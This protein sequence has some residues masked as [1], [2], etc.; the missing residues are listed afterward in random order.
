MTATTE[1]TDTPQPN[2]QGGES[3]EATSTTPA[4]SE[5]TEKSEPQG[6]QIASLLDDPKPDEKAGEGGG[7]S[8]EAK[9][10]TD[11][12]G[13]SEGEPE[14]APEAYEPFE[15][16][17]G[18]QLDETLMTSFEEAARALNLP[19]AKAQG[20]LNTMLPAMVQLEQKRLAQ[21]DADTIADPEIGGD[22]HDATIDA[23]RKALA[24]YGNKAF[25]QM[26]DQTG[27]HRHP[28]MKRMLAWVG[29]RISEDTHVGEGVPDSGNTGEMTDA[30]MRNVLHG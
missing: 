26:L 1:T 8:T 17:E 10:D 21:W 19:Q 27:L 6:E 13:D 11:A 7:E 15:A 20:F 2:T 3:Q 5:A 25:T 23:G 12:A 18:L 22:K 9:S 14:G 4:A 28:E 29:S 16:I 24:T 30:V